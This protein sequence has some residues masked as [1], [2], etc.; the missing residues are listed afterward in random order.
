MD[1][2]LG[3]INDFI[4]YLKRAIVRIYSVVLEGLKFD[5]FYQSD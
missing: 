2:K 5:L 4:E 1:I 3:L